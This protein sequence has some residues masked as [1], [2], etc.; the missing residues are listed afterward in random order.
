MTLLK[1]LLSS[2]F[3]FSRSAEESLG[4][5]ST[6]GVYML[7]VC[8]LPQRLVNLHSDSSLGSLASSPLHFFPPF[9]LNSL[10]SGALQ[11]HFSRKC[12]KVSSFLL[13]VV[14]PHD[15]AGGKLTPD[16]MSF[17]FSLLLSSQW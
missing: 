16:W 1:P 15:D 8:L 12:C 4:L 6:D 2:L 17:C 5:A 3:C 14:S 9:P 13:V 7:S 10:H 11:T